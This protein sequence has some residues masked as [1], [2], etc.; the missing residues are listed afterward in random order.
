P[1]DAQIFKKLCIL[2]WIYASTL[3]GF[4]VIHVGITT[5][6]FQSTFNHGMR[7]QKI[8]SR[9]FITASILYPCVFGYHAFH[10]E[11]LDGLTPYCSSFSKFSEPTMM[12]NLYVVEGIDVLYTFA[13]LFLWWFNPKLLRKEREEFNLKKT[14]HRKQSI[15]AIKQLL[16]VTFMHLVAYIITLIA[17]FLSTTLGKVLSKEDFLFL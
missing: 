5:Q 3:P 10:M 9:I 7:S 2:R 11:S 16:P 15:F 4:D 6:R 17:Y 14:F 1:C 12:L 8:L 13:T